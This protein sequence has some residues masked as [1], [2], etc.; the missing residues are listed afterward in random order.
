VECDYSAV[1]DS[2]VSRTNTATATQQLYTFDHLLVATADGTE[3]YSDQEPVTFGAPTT[4]TDECVT[5]FDTNLISLAN[6]T[7]MLG[8]ACAPADIPKTFTYTL[9]IGPIEEADCGEF[10]VDNTARFVTNDTQ[11]SLNDTWSVHVTVPCPE[12]CTLTQGYWKTHNESFPGGAPPDPNWFLIGDVDGDLVSEG[13]LED[14]FDTGMTWFEVFWTSPAG[15]PYYQLAHQWM[16]AYLNALSIQD[17]GGTIP[18]SIQTALNHGA[19]LL[20]EYDGVPDPLKNPDL[21]GKNAK[22]IRADFVATAGILGAFNE[23]DIGPGHCDEDTTSSLTLTGAPVLLLPIGL[24]APIAAWVRR[25]L[26]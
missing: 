8:T 25:R 7:G 22:T 26:R 19:D 24:L 2:G 17:I 20:D 3:N 12:G 9:T 18:A 10:D 14:F 15:R 1:L 23:G 13:E 16:A 11:S 21:K 4:V 5:V 6:P